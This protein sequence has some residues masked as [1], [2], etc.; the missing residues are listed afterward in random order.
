[1]SKM[2]SHEPFQH[3]QHKLWLKR[4]S[5][6]KRAIWLPTTKKLGIDPIP[7][8]VGGVR[9]IIGKLLRRATSLL[10]FRPYPN[11]RFELGVMS[12]QSP[13]SPNR[14]S[15]GTP[16]SESRDK[17]PFECRCHGQTQRILYRGRWWPPLS[18]GRGESNE[19]VL[20]V[21]CPNTKSDSKCELQVGF[22]AGPS[23]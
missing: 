5:G 19:S 12:S 13:R 6:V 20:P 14:D 1:M 3:L 23:N 16:P 10:C 17:K 18:S 21:V 2:A 9:H 22:D 4:R 7:V 15:F 11:W 8:C